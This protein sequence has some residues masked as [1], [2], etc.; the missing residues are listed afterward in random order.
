M[1]GNQPAARYTPV[2]TYGYLLLLCMGEIDTAVDRYHR[3]CA[4]LYLL[5]AVL[6]LA[7]ESSIALLYS[8]RELVLCFCA[9]R[10]FLLIAVQVSTSP[11]QKLR[12]LPTVC[13]PYVVYI[14]RK[15]NQS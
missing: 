2:A 10:R 5:H 9:P 7:R 3:C 15:Q 11:T 14:D 1:S 6:S 13:I 12:A 8:M 4:P